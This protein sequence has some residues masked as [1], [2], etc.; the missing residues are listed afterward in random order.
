[1]KDIEHS[2]NTSLTLFW[3]EVV[4][5]HNKLRNYTNCDLG[6]MFQQTIGRVFVKT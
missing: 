5:S 1:M 4:N 6:W 3:I 2:P